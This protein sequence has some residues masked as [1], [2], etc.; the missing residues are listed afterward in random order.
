MF[1]LYAIA[2]NLNMTPLIKIKNKFVPVFLEF[3]SA[4]FIGVPE[5]FLNASPIYR[6]MMR[7]GLKRNQVDQ[8]MR[9]L[10]RRGY[11]EKRGDG[12]VLTSRGKRWAVS[13]QYKYFKQ[14]N[15]KWDGKWRLIIFDIPVELQ[16]KRHSLRYRLQS[17]NA[18]M[19]QKSV[20]AFPYSCET[21][22][23]DWCGQL[24]ISDHVDILLTNTLGSK[25]VHAR[26]HFDLA[27]E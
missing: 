27:K 11:L 24:G 16:Q 15:S 26:R 2:Y 5:A 3:L 17:I 4:L 22:F 20:F 1:K 10:S 19:V 21:E 6:A 9:N 18:Y 12:Y 8:G 13:R 7:S 23:G 25:E 14:R